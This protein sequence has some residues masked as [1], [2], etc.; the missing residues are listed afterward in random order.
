MSRRDRY[1]PGGLDQYLSF[2]VFC[3]DCGF[4]GRKFLPV[5]EVLE[6]VVG[7]RKCECHSTLCTRKVDE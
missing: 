7:D 4:E 3:R 2:E 6:Y 5:R 1:V